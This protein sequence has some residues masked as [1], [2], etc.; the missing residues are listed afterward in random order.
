V[1]VRGSL[2]AADLDSRRRD[3]EKC[4]LALDACWFQQILLHA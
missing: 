4:G 1:S 3:E 2:G